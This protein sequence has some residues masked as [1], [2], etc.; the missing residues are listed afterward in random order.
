MADNQ[1]MTNNLT[2]PLEKHFHRLGEISKLTIIHGFQ[3][4]FYIWSGS[5]FEIKT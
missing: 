5:E 1:A 4:T 3:D 2:V